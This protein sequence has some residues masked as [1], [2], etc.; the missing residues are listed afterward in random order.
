MVQ[1]PL[2]VYVFGTDQKPVFPPRYY[3]KIIGISQLGSGLM[4]PNKIT[5]PS[6]DT[7]ETEYKYRTSG[8]G[9]KM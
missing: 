7:A 1:V 5:A 6:N 8:I 3:T 2:K 9:S 4:V